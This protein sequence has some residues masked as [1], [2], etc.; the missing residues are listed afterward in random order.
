MSVW[1]AIP[2]AR[3]PAEAIPTLDKWRAQ[4]YK[5]A[6]W[7]DTKPDIAKW[8]TREDGS[9]GA[10]DGLALVGGFNGI[11]KTLT[12]TFPADNLGPC[13]LYTSRCV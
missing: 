12:W 7:R 2:S 13:L 3:P 11:S 10:V 1:F 8:Y 4:G 9:Y 6:L 5:I